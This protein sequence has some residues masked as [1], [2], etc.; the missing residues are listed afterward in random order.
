MLTA[1]DLGYV[2]E[3]AEPVGYEVE[4]ADRLRPE[5][6]LGVEV[7]QVQPDAGEAGVQPE[8]A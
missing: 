1:T 3:V 7:Q 4:H 2:V 5:A 8:L 6:R